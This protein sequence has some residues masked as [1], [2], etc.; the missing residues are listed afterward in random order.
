MF[1]FELFLKISIR[2]L[3]SESI[4]IYGLITM[5]VTSFY[6]IRNLC[7]CQRFTFLNVPYMS[8]KWLLL[9]CKWENPFEIQKYHSIPQMQYFPNSFWLTC[10]SPAWTRMTRSDSLYS[11]NFP[12]C[13]PR[14]RIYFSR[15][16][17]KVFLSHTLLLRS[18]SLNAGFGAICGIS[19]Y[20]FSI[21]TGP[22][23]R[24]FAVKQSGFPSALQNKQLYLANSLI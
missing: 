6:F 5:N 8:L 10:W 17:V 15:Y 16:N 19:S 21:A 12:F 11:F 13:F 24:E 23:H 20:F 2:K 7:H 22:S 3:F 4:E 14:A 9:P 1:F 18:L